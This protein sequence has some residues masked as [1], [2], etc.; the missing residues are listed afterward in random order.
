M[1]SRVVAETISKKLAF[2]VDSFPVVLLCFVFVVV[3]VPGA[4]PEKVAACF[5]MD[6]DS[7][8]VVRF[9][10]WEASKLTNP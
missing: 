9:V 5:E 2:F 1:L 7:L 10:P 3:A 8:E 6:P 4:P